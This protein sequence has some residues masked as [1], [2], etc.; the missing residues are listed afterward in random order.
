MRG[1]ASKVEL[2]LVIS[3]PSL[4]GRSFDQNRQE[5]LPCRNLP[6]RKIVFGS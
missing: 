6:Q 2:L 4:R 3:Y 1:H 5:W